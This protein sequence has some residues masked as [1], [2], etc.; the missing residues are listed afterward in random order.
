MDPSGAS[1]VWLGESGGSSTHRSRFHTWSPL[2][3]DARSVATSVAK[4]GDP[5]LLRD[6]IAN[7]HPDDA[8]ER[9]GLNYWAYWVGEIDT[10]QRDDSFMTAELPTWRGTRL[11]RHLVERLDDTHPFVD[12][13]I[14]SVWALL[15]ARQGIAHDNL[16]T[17]RQLLGNSVKLLDSTRVSP[18][19]RRELASIVYSLRTGGLTGTGML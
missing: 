18:Q 4:Q 19:S 14:H 6:F 8:C 12:L 17:G 11:L 5:E 10:R 7:A 13:N 16:T 3:P 2:W 15:A 9:A 1:G